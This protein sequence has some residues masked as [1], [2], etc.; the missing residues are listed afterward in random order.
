MPSPQVTDVALL[1]VVKLS[2]RC[3]IASD[4]QPVAEAGERTAHAVAAFRPV[5]RNGC[6]RVVILFD[7]G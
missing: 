3:C 1:V 2:I 4:S 5:G 7:I 6:E